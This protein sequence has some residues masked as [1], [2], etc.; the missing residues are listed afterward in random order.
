[1]AIV[2]VAGLKCDKCEHTW[3]PRRGTVF[4]KVCP[5]CKSAEWNGE[6]KG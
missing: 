3:T 4:P 1:M 5:R 2:K 6:R